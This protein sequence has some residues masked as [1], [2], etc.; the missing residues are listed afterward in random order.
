M[1]GF[2][3][4]L[5]CALLLLS[6]GCDDKP[7]VPPQLAPEPVTRVAVLATVFPL[8]DVARSVGGGNVDVSWWLESG[9]IVQGFEPS[10]NQIDALLRAGVVMSG[11]TGE[12]F[13]TRFFDD[14]FN[15]R[16]IVRLDSFVPFEQRVPL[17][18]LD[19]RIV[20]QA[21]QLLADR[22]C[23][24]RPQRATEFRDAAALFSKQIDTLIDDYDT[25][26]ISL[27]GKTVLGIG[28]DYSALARH[29]GFSLIQAT[30][31]PAIRLTDEE[32]RAARRTIATGGAIMA[33]VEA[34]TPPTVLRHVQ[35]Q[36]GIPVVA[37][38]SLGTSSSQ[39]RTTYDKLMRYNFA[40]LYDGWQRSGGF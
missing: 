32:L 6:I 7:A 37:I 8:A 16:K 30:E 15:D 11:G 24:L 25:R 28:K 9:Q 4:I 2:T 26:L 3:L 39:G 12:D 10:Q 20:R 38:D 27:R 18:W 1:R 5:S 14:P 36:L 40:Q 17:L 23:V 29:V 13:A 31:R 21:A 35:E 19:P 22:L 33:L 34:D